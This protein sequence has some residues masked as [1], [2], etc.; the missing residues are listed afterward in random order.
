[1]LNNPERRGPRDEEVVW[2]RQPE[3]RGPH[4]LLPGTVG[5]ETARVGKVAQLWLRAGPGSGRLGAQPQPPSPRRGDPVN[6]AWKSWGRWLYE[7]DTWSNAGLRRASSLSQVVCVVHAAV[8]G[9]A[10]Y[11]TD[12]RALVGAWAGS[13]AFASAPQLAS[14]FGPVALAFSLALR[15]MGC[16]A[17][18]LALVRFALLHRDAALAGPRVVC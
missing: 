12:M 17:P 2:P 16:F 18:A 15:G 8:A 10:A 4:A 7:V 3:L 11:P 9:S 6:P 14:L 13:D 5:P 1:M